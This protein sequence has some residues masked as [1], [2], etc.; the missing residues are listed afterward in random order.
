MIKEM[1]IDTR[2]YTTMGEIRRKGKEIRTYD[3]KKSYIIV[4]DH[5]IQEE[6]DKP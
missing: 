4:Y 5:E 3:A 2:E 6:G 1:N